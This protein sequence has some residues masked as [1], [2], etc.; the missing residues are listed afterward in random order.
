MT[1]KQIETARAIVKAADA[2]AASES[3]TGV[4]DDQIKNA[5]ALVA[6]ED[7][8]AA[9]AKK[10][11]EDKE[12]LAASQADDPPKEFA[13]RLT[14]AEAQAKS[15]KEQAETSAAEAKRANERVDVLEKDA[16]TKRFTEI[17]SKFVGD[18]PKHIARLEAFAASE[19]GEDG[20]LFKDY[21]A[22]EQEVAAALRESV[23]FKEIGSSASGVTGTAEGEIEAKTQ[24]LMAEDPTN[25]GSH[26]KAYS[27]VL[28]RE[29]GLYDRY[30]K[31]VN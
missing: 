3:L 17:A 30:K 16:R 11:A 12:K 15:F 20:D 24:K 8:R 22:H 10:A 4:T 25:F 6:A 31:E 19:G 9:E 2:K 1:T 23:A 21:V 26:P 18:K 13:E 5:R 29:P 27:E 14:A 7:K 28:K